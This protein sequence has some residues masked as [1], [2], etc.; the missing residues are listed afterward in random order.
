MTILRYSVSCYSND[1]A[2]KLGNI[3]YVHGNVSLSGVIFFEYA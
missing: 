2:S 3:S 1:N